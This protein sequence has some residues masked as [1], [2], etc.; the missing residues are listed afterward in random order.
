MKINNKY[1]YHV[2]IL[3]EALIREV[4][5]FLDKLMSAN[6]IVQTKTYKDFGIASATLRRLRVGDSSISIAVLRKMPYVLAYNLVEYEKNLKAQ[7]F[8]QERNRKL[9]D[10]P[11]LFDEFKNLYGFQASFCL[12]LIEKGHDLREI[13]RHA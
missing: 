3:K 6:I 9:G 8:G 11:A 7:E 13:V 4:G 5:I 2:V 10:L 1:K 12:D